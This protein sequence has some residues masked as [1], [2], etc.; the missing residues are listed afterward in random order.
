M[1]PK[2]FDTDELLEKASRGDADAGQMLLAGDRDRLR[3]LVAARLDRRVLARVD[4]SDVVQEALAAAAKALPAYLRE[5]PIPFFA[6]L[7][8]FAWERLVKL[9]RFH[10]HAQR[11]SVAR[12]ERASP[13]LSEEATL[14]VVERLAANGTSPSQKLI[15]DEQHTRVRDAVSRLT[16][17]DRDVLMMRNV[18]QLTMAEVAA[19]FGITEGAAK[20]R[21]LRAVRRLRAALEDAE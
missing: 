12:E 5:R 21:H 9:H 15:R 11:R 8:Q 18:E 1:S 17:T 4:P 20:V 7:W 16:P 6:W 14:A 19:V 2:F 3:R 10:I 13:Q